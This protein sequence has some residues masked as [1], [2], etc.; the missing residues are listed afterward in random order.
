M[1]DFVDLGAL[2]SQEDPQ[3]IFSF[4]PAM[5]QQQPGLALRT[6]A[7]AHQQPEREITD[8]Q[9]L[10]P[11]YNHASSSFMQLTSCPAPNSHSEEIIAAIVNRIHNNTEFACQDDSPPEPP[12][13]RRVANRRRAKNNM[14]E[15]KRFL[16][17][18]A[19]KELSSKERHKIRN[20]VA[21]WTCRERKNG[22]L[23]HIPQFT[24]HITDM[25]SSVH[26]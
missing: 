3:D 10:Q 12:I 24:I 14:D 9:H 8:T 20:K 4:W 13:L 6:P 11:Q 26:C 15:E 25:F 1:P 23:I 21:A 16:A 2:P 17:S 22:M 19:G 18:E 7:Q 5:H